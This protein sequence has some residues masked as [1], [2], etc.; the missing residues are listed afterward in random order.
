MSTWTDEQ[1]KKII[2][3]LLIGGVVIAA[4]VVLAGGALYLARYGAMP[5]GL[6]VFQGEPADLRSVYGI[7]TDAF[8]L[9]SRGII[10]LGLL[11]L[12]A[13][14]VAR[15]VFSVIAFA[16]QRDITYVMVTLAVLAVLIY[17]LSGG[18]L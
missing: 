5:P 7:L 16:L 14:P 10:Q 18:R 3:N 15:V 11:F 6:H 12:I 17:S 1:V 2:G 9:K 4:T 13:T 8:S